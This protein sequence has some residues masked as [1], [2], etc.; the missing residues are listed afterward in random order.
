MF[1]N[2]LTKFCS[3]LAVRAINDQI[4]HLERMFIDPFGLPDRKDIRFV[5]MQSSYTCVF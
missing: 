2:I 4:M 3:V 5:N 1:I